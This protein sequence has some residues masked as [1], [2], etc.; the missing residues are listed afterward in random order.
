MALTQ[1][2]MR[3][4]KMDPASWQFPWSHGYSSAA[5]LG[6]KTNRTYATATIFTIP[7]TWRLL[8][9]AW[10]KF[11]TSG[12]MFCNTWKHQ[13]QCDSQ[14]AHCTKG[15]FPSTARLLQQVVCA[16]VCVCVCMRVHRGY[17]L[18]K[19]SE[20]IALHFKY[21]FYGWIL[22]TLW[23]MYGIVLLAHY[24]STVPT[25]SEALNVWCDELVCSLLI[26]VCVISCHIAVVLILL[27]SQNLWMPQ[28]CFSA[29]NR[30]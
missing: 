19:L 14:L 25:T 29:A 30:W 18:R 9:L 21:F 26:E 28:F 20:W 27:S 22:A 3:W 5:V 7:H 15:G 8:A 6:T 17:V 10:A 1:L 11:E 23:Y 16:C 24:Y 4:D 12:S 2:R 13:I